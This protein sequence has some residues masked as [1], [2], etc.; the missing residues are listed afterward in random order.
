MPGGFDDR[1]TV[2]G[3]IDVVGCEREV[4]DFRFLE[5]FDID[6]ADSALEF[7]SV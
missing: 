1:R 7:D 3:C 2:L 6:T 5:V 4:G